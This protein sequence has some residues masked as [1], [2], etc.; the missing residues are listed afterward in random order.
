MSV[1]TPFRKRSLVKTWVAVG[2][3]VKLA[4]MLNDP[5][6]TWVAPVAYA[7]QPQRM[8]LDQ[9]GGSSVTYIP[10]RCDN[11]TGIQS[12]VISVTSTQGEIV[13]ASTG[14]IHVCGW[15]FTSSAGAV[16][17]SF[18]Q[19]SSADACVTNETAKTGKYSLSSFSQVVVP[20]AGHVQFITSSAVSLCLNVPTAGDVTG[21]LTYIQST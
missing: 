19:G 11:S 3:A 1:F 8:N 20:N 12:T 10:V 13:Q 5:A 15:S 4:H 2:G 7:Q 9:I 14:R 6:P 17:P 16:S 21:L 18:V